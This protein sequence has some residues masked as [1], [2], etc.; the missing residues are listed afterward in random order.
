MREIESL[1][2][3]MFAPIQGQTKADPEPDDIVQEIG[4]KMAARSMKRD[5][6]D[7]MGRWKRT[8]PWM[9][10]SMTDYVEKEIEHTK[11]SI[12]NPAGY[13]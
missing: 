6:D 13:G 11:P 12:H 1:D 5:D 3:R 2:N 10:Y 9:A 7:P 8:R 4:I